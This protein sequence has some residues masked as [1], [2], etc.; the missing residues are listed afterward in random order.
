MNRNYKVKEELTVDFHVTRADKQ[1][2]GHMKNVK[3]KNMSKSIAYVPILKGEVGGKNHFFEKFIF[4][5]RHFL[6][7][8]F[9]KAEYSYTT[10]FERFC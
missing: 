7:S 5:W 4:T 6:I 10:F 9:L 2:D 3:I 8:F 1:T